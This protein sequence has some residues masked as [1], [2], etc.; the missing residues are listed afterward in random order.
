MVRLTDV[1][2]AEILQAARTVPID[3]RQIYLEQLAVELR[4]RELGDGLV[5]RLAHDVARRITWDAERTTA[6]G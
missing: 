6:V 4:G 1:Q 5:H 2:L 3:L